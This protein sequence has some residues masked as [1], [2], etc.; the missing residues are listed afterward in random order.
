M[1][2]IRDPIGRR[3]RDLRLQ[4][5]LT[6]A[7]L[8][9]RAGISRNTLIELEQDSRPARP[10]TVRKV[11]AALGVKPVRLTIGITD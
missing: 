7:E 4:H 9:E 3:V 2:D 11:A 6:Q 1:R 8:A 5:A 10:A